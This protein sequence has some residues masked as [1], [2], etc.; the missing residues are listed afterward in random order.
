MKILVTGFTG[1]TNSAKIL[2]DKIMTENKLYLENDNNISEK[3]LEKELIK[4]YD[5]LIMFGQTRKTTNDEISTLK[6]M[7]IIF[8][9]LACKENIKYLADWNFNFMKSHF[10]AAGYD[11]FISEDAGIYLCNNIYFHALKL[12]DEIHLNLK[13]VFVKIPYYENIVD[14]DHFANTIT[15]Y[16]KTLK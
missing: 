15:E 8:E 14:I 16:I 7:N 9:T 12:Q 13:S 11:V 5:Y 3:Q 1:E 2:L 10:C 4:G 6:V